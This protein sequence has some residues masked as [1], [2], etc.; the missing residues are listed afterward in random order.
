M[1]WMKSE[2]DAALIPE[3]I[4]PIAVVTYSVISSHSSSISS[5]L[6]WQILLPGKPRKIN[7]VNKA[8]PQR[9]SWL[10]RWW[11]FVRVWWHSEQRRRSCSNLSSIMQ[12]CSGGAGTV[13]STSRSVTRIK[14][15]W[16]LLHYS[17]ICQVRRRVKGSTCDLRRRRPCA[18]EYELYIKFIQIIQAL[19]SRLVNCSVRNQWK[20]GTFF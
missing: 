1:R 3:L 15:L 2:E 20:I 10:T 14:R 12:L 9:F 11:Q 5:R 6:V 16:K 4:L 7:I 19:F 13:C 18:L 17:V 8:C